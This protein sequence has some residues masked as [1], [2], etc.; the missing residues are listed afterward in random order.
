MSKK[1]TETLT[2][3]KCGKEF[4]TEFYDS[5]SVTRKYDKLKIA[6]LNESIYEHECPHCHDKNKLLVPVEYVDLLHGYRIQLG[7]LPALMNRLISWQIVSTIKSKGRSGQVIREPGFVYLGCV[8]PEDFKSKVAAFEFGL[9]YRIVTLYEASLSHSLEEVTED[10]GEVKLEV[11]N[12]RFS[13]T[14]EGEPFFHLDAYSADRDETYTI[15][16]DFDRAYYDRIRDDYS[17]YIEEVY[18]YSFDIAT[19]RKL[20]ET[21]NLGLAEEHHEHD[22]K[23]LI[24][25]METGQLTLAYVKDEDET[26]YMAND[27]ILIKKDGLGFVGTVFKVMHMSELAFPLR[28]NE[29]YVVA[30][31]DDPSAYAPDDINSDDYISIDITD[32]VKGTE[33]EEPDE[34]G[35]A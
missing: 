18:N 16:I 11:V 8:S 24:V 12:S 2:C 1:H 26:K 6:C 15:C 14:K 23:F 3:K 13:I 34:K 20:I 33:S 5:V 32:L 27:T 10:E 22:M 9:D 4:E 28:L 30:G 29:L 21:V 25:K 19:A 17:P 7:D 31:L 35:L